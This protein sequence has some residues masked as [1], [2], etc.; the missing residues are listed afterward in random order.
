MT[1][2]AREF[3]SSFLRKAFLVDRLADES[4]LIAETLE[5]ETAHLSEPRLKVLAALVWLSTYSARHFAVS[6]DAGR[7]NEKGD[8]AGEERAANPH[9]S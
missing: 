8:G 9:P 6:E 1:R 7:E 4:G 3:P 5:T 2:V